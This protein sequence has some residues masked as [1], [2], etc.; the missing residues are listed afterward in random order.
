MRDEAGVLEGTTILEELGKRHGDRFDERHLRT[1]Q[2]RIRDW[3][4]L[5]GP[6]KEVFFEQE[7]LPGR[8]GA[9]DFTDCSSLRVT[10]AGQFFSHLRFQFILSFSKWRYVALAFSETFEALVS[11]V[12]GALW[13][14][15]GAPTVLRSDNLSAA[16]HALPAGGRELN[17]RSKRFWTN[18]NVRSTRIE[19][20]KSNQNLLSSGGSGGSGTDGVRL[21]RQP[22][23]LAGGADQT[24]GL[25]DHLLP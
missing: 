24:L 17:R 3:R 14:L 8:E 2:R 22:P 23:L 11:S 5:H 7:H 6:D 15:G 1:L 10:M 25:V 12:Q 18:Y 21:Q 4:A 19:P 16:T 9:F 20:G 13:E